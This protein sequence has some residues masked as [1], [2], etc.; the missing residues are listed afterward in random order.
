MSN[1]V[2]SKEIAKTYRLAL[3]AALYIGASYYV[4]IFFLINPGVNLNSNATFMGMRL[5][6]C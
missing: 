3:I 4:T 1:G 5:P 2:R 6:G